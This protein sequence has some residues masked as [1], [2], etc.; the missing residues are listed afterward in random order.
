[1]QQICNK[2]ATSLQQVRQ[3]LAAKKKNNFAAKL[4]RDF[5]FAAVA[6]KAFLT[7]KLKMKE[8]LSGLHDLRSVEI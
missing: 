1:M 4:R 6:G 8:V 7:S 3:N 5:D 2:F